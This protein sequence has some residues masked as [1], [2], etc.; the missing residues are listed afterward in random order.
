MIV[1]QMKAIHFVPVLFVLMLINLVCQSGSGPLV[2]DD[3]TFG[4]E[5]SYYDSLVSKT[6][7]DSIIPLLEDDKNYVLFGFM[8]I[9]DDKEREHYTPSCIVISDKGDVIINSYNRYTNEKH[10]DEPLYKITDEWL[11]DDF[12]PNEDSLKYLIN[13]ALKHADFN[14][15]YIT[16]STQKPTWFTSE[17]KYFFT[18]IMKNK[19]MKGRIRLETY[20][21]A[22]QPMTDFIQLM[23]V[24]FYRGFQLQLIKRDNNTK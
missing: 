18:Y 19:E 9:L 15:K 6:Y 22:P 23:R 2:N 24:L 8:R 7:S 12:L 10:K 17:G 11:L 1:K 3:I 21:D 16:S 20:L 14:D 13:D 4:T 5:V